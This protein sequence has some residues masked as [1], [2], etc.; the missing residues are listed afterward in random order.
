MSAIGVLLLPAICAVHESLLGT[1]RTNG[2][3]LIMSV[4]EGK[5]DLLVERPNFSL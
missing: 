1:K 4:F 3:G 2:T 5:A